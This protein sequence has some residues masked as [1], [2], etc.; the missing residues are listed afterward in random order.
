[1]AYYSIYCNERMIL[2]NLDQYEIP[3]KLLKRLLYKDKTTTI[4]EKLDIY[5][6]HRTYLGDESPIRHPALDTSYVWDWNSHMEKRVCDLF[7]RYKE[8]KWMQEDFF[9]DEDTY[10]DDDW[11]V[12]W[13]NP[14][15]C[16]VEQEYNPYF[17][18]WLDIDPSSLEWKLDKNRRQEFEEGIARARNWNLREVNEVHMYKKDFDA[19]EDARK[20]RNFNELETQVMFGMI[21]VTRLF[22]GKWCKLDTKN[23]KRGFKGCF[24]RHVSDEVIEKVA[25]T[26]C[27]RKVSSG[28]DFTNYDERE[29]WYK[30]KYDW[31]YLYFDI[32]ENDEIVYTFHVTHE[33]N[34]LNLSSV[35]K[36]AM[37]DYKQKY[38]AECGKPFEPKSNRSKHCPECRKEVV[39]EQNRLRQQKYRESKKAI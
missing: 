26:K 19:I 21:F 38:C 29:G 32:D 36:E 31:K 20:R 37:P 28:K 24:D 6:E 23:R 13:T 12:G 27:F 18:K 3:N 17:E 34:K 15:M 8:I 10:L 33:N 9:E 22:G 35:F 30:F 4:D 11:S 1:M 2:D 14:H 39:K 7:Q 16:Y 25:K 5:F